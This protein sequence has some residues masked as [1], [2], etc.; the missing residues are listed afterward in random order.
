[1]PPERPLTCDR[2]PR[3]MTGTMSARDA[4]STVLMKVVERMASKALRGS[5]VAWLIASSSTGT[6]ACETVRGMVA[7]CQHQSHRCCT[8]RLVASNKRLGSSRDLASCQVALC[9][10]LF[11]VDSLSSR[12]PLTDAR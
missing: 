6:K 2:M 3:S 1:M 4:A 7:T 12:S 8:S 5:S 10:L 11:R 9:A